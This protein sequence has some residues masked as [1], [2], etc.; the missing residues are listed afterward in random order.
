MTFFFP[1]FPP[2]ITMHIIKQAVED[3]GIEKKKDIPF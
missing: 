3:L 1:T 2:L